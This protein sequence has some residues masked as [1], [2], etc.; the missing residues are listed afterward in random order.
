MSDLPIRI[1]K[2][3]TDYFQLPIDAGDL[4]RE[5]R[6]AA[7]LLEKGKWDDLL[8]ILPHNFKYYPLTCTPIRASLYLAGVII[9]YM[10]HAVGSPQNDVEDWGSHLLYFLDG[11]R[12]D[13]DVLKCSSTERQRKLIAEFGEAMETILAGV[14]ELSVL[15]IKLGVMGEQWRLPLR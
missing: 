13:L 5:W 9:C 15:G 1:R 8:A 4:W 3:W 11:E 2:E 14:P 12:W 6:D 7:R 10:L